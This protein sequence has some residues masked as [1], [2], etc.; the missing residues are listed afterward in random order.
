MVTKRLLILLV[1]IVFTLSLAS[2]G[3]SAGTVEKGV[4]GTVTKIEGSKV[5]ILDSMGNEKTI[6]VTDTE[7]LKDLKVGDH[8]SIKDGQL[9]KEKEE[10]KSPGTSRY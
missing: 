8:V 4:T 3:L 10:T 9:I 2:L 6:K 1:A 7:I 5:S